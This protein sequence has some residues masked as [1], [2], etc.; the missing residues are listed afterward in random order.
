MFYLIREGNALRQGLNVYHPFHE[1]SIGFVL[2][3]WRRG[4]RVRYSK[5]TG[6]MHVTWHVYDLDGFY[7]SKRIV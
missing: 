1:N 7:V 5:I 2:I 4:F 6:K 3:I